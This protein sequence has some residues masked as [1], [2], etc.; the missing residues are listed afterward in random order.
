VFQGVR[1]SIAPAGRWVMIGQ[2]TGDFIPFNPAQLFLKNISM[3]SVN[4]TRRDQLQDCLAMVHRGQVKPIVSNAVPLEEA[5]RVH[6]DIAQ[7]R[8][9]GRVVLKPWL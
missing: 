8:T 1:R 9:A 2:L 3:L 7:G 4:S 6:E 5:P